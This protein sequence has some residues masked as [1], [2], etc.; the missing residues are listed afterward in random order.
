VNSF[1][2][3]KKKLI[4][5]IIYDP[6]KNGILCQTKIDSLYPDILYSKDLYNTKSILHLVPGD[7]NILNDNNFDTIL[8]S[9]LSDRLKLIY[10]NILETKSPVIVKSSN[11]NETTDYKHNS[12]VII[13]IYILL[14][15]LHNS[16]PR[17]YIRLSKDNKIK[18]EQLSTILTLKKLDILTLLKDV[19][20]NVKQPI[21]NIIKDI[22]LLSYSLCQGTEEQNIKNANAQINLLNNTIKNHGTITINIYDKVKFQ[23]ILTTLFLTRR[24]GDNDQYHAYTN[25]TAPIIIPEAIYKNFSDCPVYDVSLKLVDILFNNEYLR[26]Q[27]Y[28]F[29]RHSDMVIEYIKK[30]ITFLTIKYLLQF[31]DVIFYL[32]ITPLDQLKNYNFNKL[33]THD[34]MIKTFGPNG[35]GPSL[36]TDL[37]NEKQKHYEENSV[38]RYI[39]DEIFIKY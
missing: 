37:N 19:D 26:S 17:T 25:E 10:I 16:I 4:Y 20:N 1:Y 13:K 15:D 22:I 5:H 38:I 24:Q 21:L 36:S 29:N 12:E 35:W 30:Y 34:E 2:T 8:K 39:L 18:L 23:G 31:I 32:D 6:V 33:H 14:P 9:N 28:G 3:A 7:I 27:F 11:P